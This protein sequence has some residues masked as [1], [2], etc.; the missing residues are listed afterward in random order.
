MRTKGLTRLVVFAVLCAA[1]TGLVVWHGSLSYDPSENRF[2][3]GSEFTAGALQEGD[4][5]ETGGE[6]LSADRD[7]AT[8]SIYG[9]PV[10]VY[11]DART[12][13]P[14]DQVWL[15]GTVGSDGSIDAMESIVRDP[16]ELTYMYGVSVVAAVLIA[17]RFVRDWRFSRERWGFE[18]RFRG[19]RRD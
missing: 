8:V 5:I 14:G 19:G 2:P 15:Y 1:L 12:L 11:T 18:P 7:I 16:W 4:R 9:E 17:G 3:G 13:E 6:V 10:P